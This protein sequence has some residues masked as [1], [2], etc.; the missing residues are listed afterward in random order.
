MVTGR[1]SQSAI[2]ELWHGVRVASGGGQRRFTNGS[3]VF[4]SNICVRQLKA[5]SFERAAELKRFPRVSS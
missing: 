5:I 1:L 3:A 4:C 2:A